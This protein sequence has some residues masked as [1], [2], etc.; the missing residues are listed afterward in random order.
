MMAVLGTSGVGKTVYLGMLLD[1]LSRR[2]E[3]MQILREGRFPSRY[4][5]P[6]SGR[7]PGD[8][9]L[10]KRQASRNAGTGSIAKFALRRAVGSLN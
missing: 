4:S 8:N 2:P 10:A 6:S 5:K 3:R 1:M 7:L 9:S